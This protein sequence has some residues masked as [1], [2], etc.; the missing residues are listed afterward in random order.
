MRTNRIVGLAIMIIAWGYIH[1]ISYSGTLPVLHIETEGKKEI[2]SK[3][4]YL[5]GT[6]YLDPMGADD[7]EAIEIG[8]AHV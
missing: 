4:Y 6:Y 2:T 3:E 5:N 1:G 7:I 8:R